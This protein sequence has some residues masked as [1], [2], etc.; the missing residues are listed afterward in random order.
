MNWLPFPVKRRNRLAPLAA[1]LKIA[2][3]ITASNCRTAVYIGL[4]SARDK[5]SPQVFSQIANKSVYRDF[6]DAVPDHGVHGF[7]QR[8]EWWFVKTFEVQLR[9][10]CRY[11]IERKFRFH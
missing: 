9:F 1:G 3:R 6:R 7:S 10:S 2:S 4:R 5:G 8:A 11:W